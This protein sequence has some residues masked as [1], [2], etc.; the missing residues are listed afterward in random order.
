MSTSVRF[1]WVWQRVRPVRLGGAFCRSSSCAPAAAPN[2]SAFFI[3]NPRL[4][5]LQV[6]GEIHHDRRLHQLMLQE[7]VNQVRSLLYPPGPTRLWGECPCLRLRLACG[8]LCPAPCALR[9][10]VAACWLPCCRAGPARVGLLLV[11]KHYVPLLASLTGSPLLRKPSFCLLPAP[12]TPALL[13]PVCCSG[14]KASDCARWTRRRPQMQMSSRRRRRRRRPPCTTGRR[15]SNR[16][17]AMAAGPVTA[18]SACMPRR[19]SWPTALQ[20]RLAAW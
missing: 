2:P 1:V 19:P 18:R 7:E 14:R 8:C 6:R 13:P 20:P 3:L 11:G 17:A 12:L 9:S 5:L 15:A 10:L 16:W 4:L